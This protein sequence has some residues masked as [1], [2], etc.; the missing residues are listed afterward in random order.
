MKKLLFLFL[1]PYFS[2]TQ[3]DTIFDKDESVIVC[4]ITL[5]NNYNIFYTEKQVGKSIEL[6]KV[7]LYSLNGKKIDPLKNTVLVKDSVSIPSKSVST[8]SKRPKVFANEGI[9]VK[10]N[11]E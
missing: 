8:K 2:W 3:T 6:K 7:K 1:L 11:E 4:K 10:Y 9:I 5:V